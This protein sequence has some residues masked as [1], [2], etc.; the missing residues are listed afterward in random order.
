MFYGFRFDSL[1]RY[2]RP[3]ELST[4]QDV[5]DYVLT[6]K[7]HYPRV[8]ITSQVSDTIQVEAVNGQIE[9]PKQWVLLEIKQT[10]LDKPDIF[11]A[12]AFTKA[13]NRAGFTRFPEPELRYEALMILERFYESLPNPA[14]GN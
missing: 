7:P 11:N 12:E 2:D 5:Y 10:Y 3:D 9:F 13:M 6:H 8:R 1:G 4:V 14:E